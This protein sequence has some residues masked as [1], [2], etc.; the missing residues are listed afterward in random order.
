MFDVFL[1]IPLLHPVLRSFVSLL[2]LSS[3]IVRSALT[4][5]SLSLP[6]TSLL[7]ISLGHFL[8]YILTFALSYQ[9]PSKLSSTPS[10]TVIVSFTL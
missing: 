8:L 10:R 5:F 9:P 3:F 1:C 7:F 6:F 4:C 2:P